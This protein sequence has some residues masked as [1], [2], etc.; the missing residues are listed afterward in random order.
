MTKKNG[1]AEPLIGHNSNLTSAHETKLAGYIAEIEHFNEEAKE[2]SAARSEVLKAAKEDGFHVG[3]IK[4]LVK[5][6]AMEREERDSLDNAIDAYRTAMGDFL[7]TPLGQ[8]MQP[9]R[10]EA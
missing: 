6:R 9:D 3:A 10:A 5:L 4:H 8:A 1:A 2:I 7:T